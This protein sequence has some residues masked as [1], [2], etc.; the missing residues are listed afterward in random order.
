LQPARHDQFAQL[1]EKLLLQLL[2]AHQSK[3]DQHGE[4]VVAAAVR[5]TF[6]A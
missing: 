2:I 4:I 6:A 1:V 3:W 5:A